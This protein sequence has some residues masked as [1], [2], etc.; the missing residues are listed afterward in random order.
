MREGALPNVLGSE[1]C[2]VSI[3]KARRQLTGIYVLGTLARLV[4]MHSNLFAAYPQLAQ[5]GPNLNALVC[6]VND[7]TGDRWLWRNLCNVLPLLVGFG[8]DR[9]PRFI[10]VINLNPSLQQSRLDNVCRLDNGRS[11]VVENSLLL[12]SILS[13]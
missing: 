12:F 5:L 1:T 4:Q 9:R 10:K 8:K 7:E 11:F 13:G 6:S 2:R 3:H